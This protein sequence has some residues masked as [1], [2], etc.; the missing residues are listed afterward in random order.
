MHLR[1]IVKNSDIFTRDRS[2]RQG[3]KRAGKRK[4]LTRYTTVQQQ[5]GRALVNNNEIPKGLRE[6][7]AV[8]EK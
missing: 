8:L 4:Q 2:L 5:N 6:K 1:Y 3:A 7:V